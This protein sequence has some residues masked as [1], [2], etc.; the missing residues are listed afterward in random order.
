MERLIEM[1]TENGPVYLTV[2]QYNA[3]LQP[4][5]M[6]EL[7]GEGEGGNSYN[8]YNYININPIN[9]IKR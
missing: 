7:G 4:L 9:I 8:Y 5:S 6:P 1:Q 2:D 3:M